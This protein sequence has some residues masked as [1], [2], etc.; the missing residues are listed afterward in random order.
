[1][2]RVIETIP[3]ATMDALS[4]YHWPGNIRELQNVIERAVIISTGPVLKVD[5]ADLKI[6]KSSSPAEK[7]SAH[8]ST[9]DGLHNMLEQ[10][11]RQ[12]ILKALKQSNWVV[13]GPES[14]A[15]KTWIKRST[16][17]LTISKVRKSRHFSELAL[18]SLFIFD[19][20]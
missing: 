16:P 20:I 8:A 17:Q 1:M 4:R 2:S 5:V 9:N 19:D 15:A 7:G 3:S 6:Y 14:A 11:E 13:A 10:T 18:P 12:Q